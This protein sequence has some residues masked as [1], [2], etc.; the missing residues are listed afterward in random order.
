MGRSACTTSGDRKDPLD[1][2]LHFL[3]PVLC[4]AVDEERDSVW[5]FKMV[6][7]RNKWARDQSIMCDVVPMYQDTVHCL[8]L[9]VHM[10]S[11]D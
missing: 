5:P 10:G 11:L 2:V 7:S 4:V 9:V 1:V 8:D 3:L 6:H